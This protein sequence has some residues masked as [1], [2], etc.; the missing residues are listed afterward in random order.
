MFFDRYEIHIQAFA[1]VLMENY[2]FPILISTN[3]ILRNIYS[4]YCSKNKFREINNMFQ[5]NSG[6][7]FQTNRTFSNFQIIRYENNILKGDSICFLYFLA[8]W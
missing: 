5:K 1:N 8:I 2:H 3:N 6:C 4:K 7:A